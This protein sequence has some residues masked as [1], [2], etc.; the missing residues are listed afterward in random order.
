MYAQWPSNTATRTVNVPP[1]LLE[2]LC[3][4]AAAAHLTIERLTRDNPAA[5]TLAEIIAFLAPEPVPLAFFTA[6]ADQLQEPLVP[7]AADTLTWRKLVTAL[8]AVP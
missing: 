4:T 5:A 2:L 6:A 3:S 7:A 8:G 1:A